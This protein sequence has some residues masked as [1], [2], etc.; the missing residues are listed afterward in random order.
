MTLTRE[1]QEALAAADAA[2]KFVLAEYE[3]FTPIPD[4]PANISTAVDRG[5]QEMIFQHLRAAFPDDGVFGEEVDGAAGPADATRVW[6]VDP[7]DGT[8]GFAMKSGDFS[9]MIG[10][11]IAG[12]VVLGVVLEP[13]IARLTYATRGG[14]CWSSIAGA[15]PT[16][17]SVSTQSEL[18]AMTLVISRQKPGKPSR[19]A[20]AMQPAKL[21]E[22]YSAGI[23]LALVARGEADVYVNSYSNVY[24]W[25]VCAGQI[26]VE[27]AGGKVTELD[28]KAIRYGQPSAIRNGT[29]ATNGRLHDTVL[30]RL[31]P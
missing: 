17:Q 13:T 15:V 4:A 14:G 8:R 26:L 10:L 3:T 2:G 30:Q 9:I 18:S 24:D 6:V 19:I 11:T 29:V 28:G 1:L 31:A 27:E 25:D 20:S 23:K 22:T 5:S 21:I 12:E 16:R 7:I